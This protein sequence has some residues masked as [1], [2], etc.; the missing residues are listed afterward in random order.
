MT[1]IE[2]LVVLALVALVAAISLP[3]AREARSAFQLRLTAELLV[4]ELAG[5]RAW[6]VSHNSL[7]TVRIA[8]TGA[9]YGFAVPGREP[10][11]WIGLP[12]GI[13]FVRR[14]RHPLTFHSRGNV[15]PAA[16]RVCGRQR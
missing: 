2:C 3:L 11:R 8:A 15:A 14:P 12:S 7:V 5:I 16:A 6:A 1:L 9:A 13:H 10:E 4:S